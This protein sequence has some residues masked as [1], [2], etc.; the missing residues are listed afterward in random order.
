MS[1]VS[2]QVI[3][4]VLTDF[5][6]CMHCEQIFDQADIGRQVHQEELEQ[7]PVE[8]R[9]ETARL[10]DWLSELTQQYGDRIY[11]RVIDPQSPE[12]LLKSVRYWVRKYPTFIVDGKKALAGWDR[13]RLEQALQARLAG[14]QLPS[15][16]SQNAAAT[17][18]SSGILQVPKRLKAAIES[19]L[20]TLREVIYGMTVYDWVHELEKARNE[21]D[22]LFTLIVYGDLLGV[23][24]LPPYYTMR[25]L[26]YMVPTL[27]NW[28][29]SMLRERDLTDLIDQEI[30]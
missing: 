30:G 26:P 20:Q 8:F 28:R 16:T 11:I 14:R 18:L 3:A 7:Y 29:R 25:L 1:R 5:F 17:K 12:G 19:A 2:V 22:R 10:A 24:I 21:Q 13:E 15:Q 6:H 23:P 4:P 27:E 9:E